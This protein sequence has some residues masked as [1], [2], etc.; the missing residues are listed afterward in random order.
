MKICSLPFSEFIQDFELESREFGICF[1]ATVNFNVMMQ[2]FCVQ[3]DVHMEALYS[4]EIDT[5]RLL[6]PII[7]QYKMP[8]SFNEVSHQ[9]LYIHNTALLIGGH[10]NLFGPFTISIF[11]RNQAVNPA[12]LAEIKS[13]KLN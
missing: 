4:G 9:F 1:S 3:T 5:I 8:V 7:E 13:K 11:P 12:S 2:N 10:I 6:N